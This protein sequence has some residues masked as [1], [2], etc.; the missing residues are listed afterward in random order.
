[1]PARR[2]I[3]L[4]CVM[5]AANTVSIG[6]FPALLPE[7]AAAGGLADWQLGAVAGA[8]GLA[9]MIANVPAGLFMSNHLTHAVL[10]APAFLLAGALVMAAGGTFVT[11][12]MGRVLMGV[13]H[14]L[15]TLGGLT[16]LLRY[17]AG[18]R[19]A[20]SLGALEFAAML[21][22]LS[23]A[24]LLS[25]LPRSM[26]WHTAWLLACAPLATGLLLLPALRRA[27]PR[28]D[29]DPSRPLFA[30]TERA[31]PGQ[32]DGSLDRPVGPGGRDTRLALLATIA[33]GAVA[34]SYAT[35]EQFV[36]PLRG[37]REFGLDRAGIAQLLMLSQAVDLV[38]LLPLG[39][40]ADRRGTPL[41]LGGVLL[42]FS[43]A[44]ALIGF[45]G[46]PLM[47][48]GCALFG[49]SMA[50]W[51]LPLGIL[52]SATPPAQVAWRTALYRVSVDGGM[53]VGPFVAGLLT[54]RHVG[55]LPVVMTVVL[56]TVGLALLR[57]GRVTEL[58]R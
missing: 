25:L 48:T 11:L 22:V 6:A 30:R 4:L 24:A 26:P 32:G 5:G 46:L 31:A 14:T 33:G 45:G 57:V 36:I 9:R 2:L 37:S 12:L 50:G 16:A 34:V 56:A 38:A 35:V 40:L 28:T 44:L 3:A 27:L 58:A 1:M 21:G 8:F 54:A 29:P 42:V 49:L 41:V 55:V 18:S 23:G 20:S 19:L 52:R 13:G 15:S 10:V 47:V 17:R 39:A 51:M 43:A 7:L 53:F